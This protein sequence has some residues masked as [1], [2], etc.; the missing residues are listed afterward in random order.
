V[1]RI[2]RSTPIPAPDAPLAT[3]AHFPTATAPAR[4]WSR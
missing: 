2:A 1:Q 3:P 4:P